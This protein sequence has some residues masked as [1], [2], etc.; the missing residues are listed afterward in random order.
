MDPSTFTAS[1]P[2]IGILRVPYTGGNGGAYP[3]GTAISSTDNTG[4]TATLKAG[5]LQYGNGVLVYDVVGTPTASSPTGATFA[6]SFGTTNP[7]NCTTTVGVISVAKT[8]GIATMGPLIATSDNGFNGYHRMLTTPDGKFS[9]RVFANPAGNLELADIQ[10]RSNNG[11]QTIMW[12]GHYAWAGGANCAASNALALI[13]GDTWYGSA[14]ETSNTATTGLN[15]AWGNADVYFT[16]PEQRTY[17]WTT[18]SVSDQT[19]YI[20]KFMMGAPSPSIVANATN[21]ATVKA[22]LQIEQIVAGN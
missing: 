13:A 8:S 2:Y 15:A 9:V 10:I 14:S 3:A 22:F 4:L 20:L 7:Q 19:M 11:A 12:S 17:M 16:A 21:A 5:D 6:L 1:S 18:T